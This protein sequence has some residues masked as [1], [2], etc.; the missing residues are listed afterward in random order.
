MPAE[1]APKASIGHK[2]MSMGSVFLRQ[3]KSYALRCSFDLK[4]KGT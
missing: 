2:L 3:K 1:G 4:Q